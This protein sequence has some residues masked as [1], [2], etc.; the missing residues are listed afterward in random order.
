MSLVVTPK[1]ILYPES[2]GQPMAD[3]T[4][5]FQWIVTIKGGL[6]HLF[7]D[8]PDVFV[9]GDLLWYPVEG[10]PELSAAP[11]VM[12]AFGRPKGHR[13]SY[14]MWAEANIPPQVVFEI[15]SPNNRIGEMSRKFD[16]YRKH[17]VEEYY[18]YNP[19]PDR[20]E[21]SGFLRRDHDLIEVPSMNGH[22]S[23]RLGV[24]FDMTPDGLVLIRP[25]G[26]PF[27]TFEEL[28]ES[29]ERAQLRLKTERERAEQE[30][31]RAEQEKQRADRSQQ[32]VEALRAQLRALGHDPK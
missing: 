31:H 19:D 11:D 26:R 22:V 20:L 21:L 14:L 6:D 25:D 15:L 27:V 16:F 24:R 10:H 12:V 18:I 30:K 2:D 5:Q 9:A 1:R 28:A 29:E 3:N 4:L 8:N 13:G 17:G 7:A 32:E 23:R